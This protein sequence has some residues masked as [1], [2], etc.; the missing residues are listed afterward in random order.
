LAA[1]HSAPASFFSL[2][3]LRLNK[4]GAVIRVMT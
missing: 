4:N 3:T 2:L 1:A